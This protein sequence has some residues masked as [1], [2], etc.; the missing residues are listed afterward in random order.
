MTWQVFDFGASGTTV[1]DGANIFTGSINCSSLK[2]SAALINDLTAGQITTTSLNFTPVLGG[3]TGSTVL[4]S[5]NS[6]LEGVRISANRLNIDANTTFGSGY[7]PTLVQASAATD[8]TTKA[9]NAA[10]PTAVGDGVVAGFVYVGPS[11][12]KTDWQGTQLLYTTSRTNM[13]LQTGFASGWSTSSLAVTTGIADPNGGTT[14]NRATWTALTYPQAIGTSVTVVSGQTYTISFWFKHDVVGVLVGVTSNAANLSCS[15]N[16]LSTGGWQRVTATGVASGSGL[17]NIVLVLNASG[18]ATTSGCNYVAP[19]FELG[20]A[21][22]SYIAS[23]AS[24]GTVTDYAVV[25]GI[26]TLSPVPLAGTIIRGVS[27]NASAA[28]AAAAASALLANNEINNIASTNVLATSDKTEVIIDYNNIIN[29]QSGLSTQATAYATSTG[30]TAAYTAYAGYITTLTAYLTGL[31]PAWNDVTIGHDTT[32]VGTTFMLNFQNVYS[33]R[34]TLLN[35][36]YAGAQTLANAAQLT[37]NNLI[38]GST[39]IGGENLAFNGNME[40]KTTYPTGWGLYN[41]GADAGATFTSGTGGVYGD[42]TALTTYTTAHSTMGMLANGTSTGN[43]AGW[44]PNKSYMLSFMARGSGASLG[45]NL[46]TAWNVLPTTITP[47]LNPTLTAGWQRY[48]FKIQMGASV[49]TLGHIFITLNTTTFPLLAAGTVEFDGVE[50]DDGSV[51]IGWQPCAREATADIATAQGVANAANA[52]VADITADDKLSAAEKQ[53][54]KPM[55]DGWVA[56]QA[57]F[58]TQ[59]NSS[60]F[61]IA[62]CA[63]KTA[64]DAALAALVTYCVTTRAIWMDLTV[65]TDLTAGG[66]AALRLLISTLLTAKQVLLNKI[67]STAN[68]NA[69]STASSDATTKANAAILL[70]QQ[71]AANQVKP[72]NF[73]DFAGAAFPAPWIISQQGT[74]STSDSGTSTTFSSS[75]TDPQIVTSALSIDPMQ[76][77]AIAVRMKVVTC[78]SW[79]GNVYYGNTGHGS[80]A[81]YLA[82][83]PMPPLGV[84]T[85]VV[86]D[87]RTL[88]LGGADYTSNGYINLLRFDFG[89]SADTVVV[90]DWIAV[91]TFGSVSAADVLAAQVAGAAS[92]V[93]TVK[94]MYGASA[95]QTQIDGGRIYTNTITTAALQ[96]GSITTDKLTVGVVNRTNLV[97]NGHFGTYATYGD[98]VNGWTIDGT[99]TQPGVTTYDT[100]TGTLNVTRLRGGAPAIVYGE[101]F[102][103]VTPGRVYSVVGLMKAVPSVDNGTG[104]MW[105]RVYD[106]TYVTRLSNATTGVA[107]GTNVPVFYTGNGATLV[108]NAADTASVR[109]AWKLFAYRITIP[110]GVTQIRLQFGA[111]SYTGG[112]TFDLSPA[113]L[114]VYDD[115]LAEAGSSMDIVNQMQL[116][117]FGGDV[118][119]SY[120]N[121]SIRSFA[122]R[123]FSTAAPTTGNL[124]GWNGSNWA[125]MTPVSAIGYTPMNK[126][127]DTFLGATGI[128]LGGASGQS[129]EDFNIS[130]GVN[131]NF[132]FAN[133]QIGGQTIGLAYLKWERGTGQDRMFSI[134]TCDAGATSHQALYCD[135]SGNTTLNAVTASSATLNGFSF[136][137]NIFAVPSAARIQG[138]NYLVINSA[139]AN[140]IYMNWDSGTGVLFGNGAGVQKASVD[141]SGNWVGAAGTFTSLIG[142]ASVTTP[143][144]AIS[145]G[146]QLTNYWG[147]SGYAN[148]MFIY[149]P[150]AY[151]YEYG[152]LN[153]AQTKW[154][155][156]V[157]A[158]GASMEIVQPLVIDSTATVA[159][160]FRTNG[161]TRIGEPATYQAPS[162]GSD[163]GSFALI[164]A[165]GLYGMYAGVSSNGDT[166]FQS[167]RNDANSLVYQLSFQPAGGNTLFGGAIVAQSITMAGNLTLNTNSASIIGKDSGGTQYSILTVSPDTN[168]YTQLWAVNNTSGFR[169][170][171]QSAG[172]SWAWLNGTNFS[173]IGQIGSSTMAAT[174]W[175]SANNF[176]TNSG[177]GNGLAFWGL[178]TSYSV[179]MSGATDATWGGRITTTLLSDTTS[180]YNMYFNMSGGTNRGWSFKSGNGGTV[181]ANID[182]AGNIRGIGNIIGAGYQSNANYGST[183]T[184]SYH[185]SGINNAST[186]WQQGTLFTYGTVQDHLG[187]AYSISSTTGAA[188]FKALTATTLTTTGQ[189]ASNSGAI[190]TVVSYSGVYGVLGTLTNNTLQFWTNSVSRAQLDSGNLTLAAGIGLASTGPLS[191]TT[192][193]LTSNVNANTSGNTGGVGFSLWGASMSNSIFMDTAASSGGWDQANADYNTYFRQNGNRRGAVFT[194]TGGGAYAQLEPISGAAAGGR[195]ILKDITNGLGYAIYFSGGVMYAVQVT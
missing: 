18:S 182:A 177:N 150:S 113:F 26:A 24:Q 7:D 162:L 31:S 86:F 71:L 48:A 13:L 74:S 32:I 141:A 161:L 104:N 75:G 59:C 65:T 156:R 57:S 174:T 39:L 144:V 51:V 152:I 160:T 37:G 30:V 131:T 8:A 165:D 181:L 133:V 19:Q 189:I 151:T 109:N 88:A 192:A 118:Q 20:A 44:M 124:I 130:T 195:L 110:A 185:P 33:S 77:Y 68:S 194:N 34:Q 107:A 168:S 67:A 63:E 183:G 87:M 159:G 184:A 1:I 163:Y 70:A 119:G 28:A 138:S 193:S 25:G 134:Y 55:Y 93:T 190:T 96:A 23:G 9:N 178:A 135:A 41:N 94:T 103:T 180:D 15:T 69:V 47:I 143:T 171:S 29:E 64:Y 154:I 126:A 149:N 16:V 84:W 132:K 147:A 120:N 78:S 83:Q 58:T 81:S 76:N 115:N 40:K 73:Y 157:P 42:A 97:V 98:T 158:G 116:V 3:T 52:V 127:G 14:A 155:F 148:T 10:I 121:L 80:S 137:S 166:W 175:I 4:A 91:G 53:S 22:T 169:F 5:I 43:I 108:A 100:G 95:D 82:Y 146:G 11:I 187:T 170:V 173:H 128:T 92:A 142:S 125:P 6:S 50:L 153:S 188:S 54:L 186:L 101:Q 45:L 66:G 129:I 102:I 191:G 27:T 172:A 123:T 99:V 38:N 117:A 105:L 167:Q 139:A 61:N 145:N 17:A 136:S 79:Q 112:G 62:A 12:T 21:A 46:Q 89:Q 164:S 114:Q 122:G 2:T 176:L 49:E 106:S 90:I 60:N 85:T 36:I 140:P 56:E 35:A 111:D 72:S 179:E